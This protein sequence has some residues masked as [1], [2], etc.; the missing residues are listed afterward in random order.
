MPEVF[1]M[2]VAIREILAKNASRVAPIAEHH[3]FC[4]KDTPSDAIMKNNFLWK[5]RRIPLS[6][7]NFDMS[8][9][10]PNV[11]IKLVS[12]FKHRHGLSEIGESK[13]T[14][15]SLMYSGRKSV[16]KVGSFPFLRGPNRRKC[17]VVV[18]KAAKN[19]C[20]F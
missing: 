17:Q 2:G 11:P 5:H 16:T 18:T 14:A 13:S 6:G 3:L 10:V 4:E 19:L 12:A 8:F 1:G 9:T 20:T 15:W 7:E